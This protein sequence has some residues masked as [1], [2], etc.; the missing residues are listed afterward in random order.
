MQKL[1]I[2]KFP[3]IQKSIAKKVTDHLIL[4][5]LVER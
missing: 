3:Q 5:G 4:Y 1:D 2:F